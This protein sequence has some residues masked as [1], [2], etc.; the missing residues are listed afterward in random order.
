M[1]KVITDSRILESIDKEIIGFELLRSFILNISKDYDLSK[2]LYEVYYT[3]GS[4]EYNF[5]T[6]TIFINIEDITKESIRTYY[7]NKD[8]YERYGLGYNKELLTNAWILFTILHE[9]EHVFQNKMIHE[10]ENDIFSFIINSEYEFIKDSNNKKIYDEYHNYFYFER[11][12]TFK[13]LETV[14]NTLKE[15]GNRDGVLDNVLQELVQFLKDGYRFKDGK[16]V[17]PIETIVELT[18]MKELL[19]IVKSLNL[20]YYEKYKDGFP[21]PIKKYS[22]ARQMIISKYL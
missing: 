4:S 6:K 1:S 7:L 17:S 9:V 10:D 21:I 20:S 19:K 22:S 5:S 16:L 11:I 8:M 3:K 13:A 12:A 15:R 14:I 18:N 2:Y